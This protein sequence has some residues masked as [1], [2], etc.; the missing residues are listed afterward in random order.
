MLSFVVTPTGDVIE[1]M[2]EDS[3]G[4]EAFEVAALRAVERWRFNPA[5]EGGKPVEQS[6]TKTIIRFQI[7]EA[8]GVTP[9]FLNKYRQITRR[10][11]QGDLAAAQQL[12]TELESGEK[13]NLYEDAWFWWLRFAYLE[14][15]KSPDT[16]AMLRSLQRAVGYEQ[17]L[18]N[19]ELLVAAAQRLFVLHVRALDFSAAVNTFERL[20]DS[21]HA[22]RADPYE[23][24]IAAL[25]PTYERILE[26]AR[27]NQR[28][29]M[30]GRVGDNDYWV[31]DLL[32][33]SFSLADVSGR[34]DVVDIR[35]DRGTKRYDAIPPESVWRIP[36]SWGKCGVYI[37]GEPGTTFV[38]EEYPA[39]F[40]STALI[41]VSEPA[42]TP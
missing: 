3:S 39:D 32:R 28:L 7:E 26:V 16:D 10:V 37:K 36:A 5:L 41:D 2:I 40:T 23:D 35:C 29:V 34:L 19:P 4:I 38:L 20:R 33:R 24:A 30:N 15:A 18:L 11:E 27:G 31:H 42:G 22:R 25:T 8:S 14:A 12:I 6:M 21:Q 13:F 9:A 17:N 1:P